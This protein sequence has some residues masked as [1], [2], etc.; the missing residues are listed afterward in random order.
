[1]AVYGLFVW[2]KSQ[3][4]LIDVLWLHQPV[5]IGPPALNFVDL[6]DKLC[7]LGTLIRFMITGRMADIVVTFKLL[8]LVE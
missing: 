6:I 7:N 5:F 3:I 4:D 1:M 2:N 8:T